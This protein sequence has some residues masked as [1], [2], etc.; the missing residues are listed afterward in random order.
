MRL[1]VATVMGSLAVVMGCSGASHVGATEA[2]GGATAPKPMRAPDWSRRPGYQANVL[3]LARA[4]DDNRRILYT[5]PRT[6]L[7]LVTVP[8]GGDVGLE[9]HP[10]VEQLVFVADGR[11]KAILDGAESQVGPGDV[12]VVTPGTRHDFVN[13][14]AEPLRMYTVYA[15]LEYFDG[16]GVH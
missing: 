2:Q 4:N 15:P 9:A 14:G 5:S 13:P 3:A 6:Q 1:G 16:G 12:V 8:P 10:Y 11:G 7:A